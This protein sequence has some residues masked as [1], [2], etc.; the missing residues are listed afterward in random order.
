MPVFRFRENEIQDPAVADAFKELAVILDNIEREKGLILDILRVSGIAAVL[1][2]EETDQA[3]DEKIWRIDSFGSDFRIATRTDVSGIG[4]D[5]IR[6]SRTGTVIDDIRLLPPL[7]LLER[8]AAGADTST[9][10]QLFVK[11]TTPQQLWFRDEAGAETQ[12][13]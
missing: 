1:E 9:Y 4:N 10:G 5:L 2:I 8:A 6:A 3:T 13:V 12:L 7:K 11:N